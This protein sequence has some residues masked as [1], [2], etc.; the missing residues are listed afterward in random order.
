MALKS[1]AGSRN[2]HRKTDVVIVTAFDDGYMRGVAIQR[3]ASA[4]AS[5]HAAA[6]ML[7]RTIQ[8]VFTET[9]HL[10]ANNGA[11]EAKPPQT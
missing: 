9:T 2:R 5:K 3:G 4:L 10:S 8:R 11:Y 1:A 7:E 6:E